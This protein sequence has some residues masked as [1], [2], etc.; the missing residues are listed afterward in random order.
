MEYLD[1]LIRKKLQYKTLKEM[2]KNSMLTERYK[3]KR[4]KG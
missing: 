1:L 2:K 3:E 4:F